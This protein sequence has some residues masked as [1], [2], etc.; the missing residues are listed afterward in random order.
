MCSR[1]SALRA[2]RHT[3]N[4][5]SEAFGQ[6]L[7]AGRAL[8]SL[9]TAGERSS[10]AVP[11]HSGVA[12][13]TGPKAGLAGLTWIRVCRHAEGW[14]QCKEGMQDERS[15]V[16]RLAESSPLLLQPCIMIPLGI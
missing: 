9:G 10:A 13:G 8:P 14:L 16:M 2:L 12:A 3:W 11:E 5:N 7:V 6:L 4:S 15:M 1:G